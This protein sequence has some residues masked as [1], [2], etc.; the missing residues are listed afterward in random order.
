M[1]KDV[2]GVS[3]D[4]REIFLNYNWP[5]NV[6]ELK[7]VIEGA[8]NIIGSRYI[9]LNDLPSYLVN[10][11]KDEIVKVKTMN[12]EMSLYEMINKYEK[13]LLIKTLSTSTTLAEAAKKL[14]ISK[15]SLNYK[16][17]KYNLK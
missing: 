1:N 14:K 7:N 15:Q 13:Q 3:D 11:F 12:D 9:E 6:R 2:E 8:F 16:L 10:Q 5:G 17:I 4:V